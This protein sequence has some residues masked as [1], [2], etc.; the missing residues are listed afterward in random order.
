MFKRLESFN[1]LQVYSTV[2]LNTDNKACLNSMKIRFSEQW[3]YV[4]YADYVHTTQLHTAQQFRCANRCLFVYV[5]NCNTYS[6][7][8]TKEPIHIRHTQLYSA[9]KNLTVAT[10]FGSYQATVSR[11]KII[12]CTI[13][14]LYNIERPEDDL[15]RA[16]TCSNCWVF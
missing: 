14:S 4:R 7:T 1:K 6:T 2:K 12:Q 11:C 5:A 3:G 8:Y 13:F 16:E 10:S 9:L 15:I